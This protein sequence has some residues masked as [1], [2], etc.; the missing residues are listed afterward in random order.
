MKQRVNLDQGV[1]QMAVEITTGHR[2][3]ATA[4]RMADAAQRYLD[5][6]D[7][8]RRKAT[9]FTFEDQERYQW[10]Y[11]PD[12]FFIGGSTFWHE[13]LRLITMTP[14]QQV[15]FVTYAR[16][17]NNMPATT[18]DTSTITTTQT[19]ETT[20]VAAQ[21][22]GSTMA[23]AFSSTL[24]AAVQP[25]YMSL[26]SDMPTTR[27]TSTSFGLQFAVRAGPCPAK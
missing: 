16:D 12:G 3:P 7:D 14:D 2:A 25:I 10:N 24:A 21:P 18:T 23:L 22:F 17:L 27:G 6:L 26:A 5:S 13:G 9:S 20:G 11:R 1:E 8:A 19:T 4:R 15:Q